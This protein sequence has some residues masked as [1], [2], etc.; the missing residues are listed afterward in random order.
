VC[1][2]NNWKAL[3]ICTL[4]GW[5]QNGDKKKFLETGSSFPPAFRAI[6]EKAPEDSLKVWT[7][8]DLKVLPG[9]VNGNMALL[10][11]V[12]RLTCS[13]ITNALSVT[14]PILSYHIKPRV[15]LKRL[16]TLFRLLQSSH[17][18]PRRKKST[19]A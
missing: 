19:I 18:E 11:Y 17:W 6:L 12:F 9:W 2:R 15:E 3:L 16:K 13:I 8:L 7:L 5:N 4:T 14:Q 10:G 1:S